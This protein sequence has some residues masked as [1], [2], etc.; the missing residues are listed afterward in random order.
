LPDG[1][2][3]RGEM[4][5]QKMVHQALHAFPEYVSDFTLLERAERLSLYGTIELG[6]LRFRIQLRQ[7]KQE[8]ER[9]KG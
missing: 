5:R 3:Y 8:F 4:P 1:R 2:S 7:I 6:G 9:L